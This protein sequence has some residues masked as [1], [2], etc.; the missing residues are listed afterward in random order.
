MSYETYSTLFMIS[1]IV[2]ALGL[3]SAIGT[4]FAFDIKTIYAIRSG[5][6]LRKAMAESQEQYAATGSMR[7][8]MDFDYDTQT[9][10]K[11]NRS[12]RFKS[13]MGKS[14]KLASGKLPAPQLSTVD[15]LPETES[16][17]GPA[18]AIQPPA[19]AMP[20]PSAAMPAPAAEPIAETTVLDEPGLSAQPSRFE[21]AVKPV[22]TPGFRFEML[23]DVV[24]THTDE[25]VY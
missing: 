25:I 19:A 8:N 12:S 11:K 17:S 23:E 16:M 14:Q 2:A 7:P 5:K 3:I 13:K 18:P 4:F 1:T 24:V 15:N 22:P 21:K 6:D 10:G 9:L 20:S